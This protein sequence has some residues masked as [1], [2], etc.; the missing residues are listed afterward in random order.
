MVQELLEVKHGIWIDEQWIRDAGLGDRLRILVQ[1]G[2]IRI[3][4]GNVEN[5]PNE[6]SKG[7][8]VFRSLGDD[9]PSGNLENAAEAHDRYL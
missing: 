4:P 6:S 1:P 8:E 7:W 9:A 5:E 2:E 3:L